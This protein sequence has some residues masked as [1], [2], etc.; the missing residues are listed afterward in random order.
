MVP[1]MCI[2][3]S[4]IMGPVMAPIVMGP[5]MAPM[6]PSWFLTCLVVYDYYLLAANYH[7][8][9]YLFAVSKCFLAAWGYIL[10][11]NFYFLAVNG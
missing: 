5:V 2:T 4:P 6:V 7:Y 11:A 3:V 10:V 9:Y 1:I 8:Y